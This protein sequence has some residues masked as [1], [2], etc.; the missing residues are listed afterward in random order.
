MEKDMVAAKG[1]THVIVVASYFYPKIGGLE[2]YSYLLAKKL[3]ESGKYR[4]SVI[5][6]NYDGKGYK[7][8][9]IDGMMIH[10]LPV[11]F[12][13][14]NTP[15]NLTW[16][17]QI[18]RIFADDRPDILHLHSPVPFMTDIAA[19]VA[20]KEVPVVLTYH[21]GSMLKNS[22]P[23]DMLLSFYE[24]IFLYKLFKRANKIVTISQ[25]FAKKKFP[26]FIEKMCF[27]PTGVDLTRFK[28]TP[29]PESEII[30]FVGRIE[31]SSSWKGIEQ[32]LQ[33]IKI[34]LIQRPNAKLELVGSGDAV[35]HYRQRAEVLGIGSSVKL[36]GSLIGQDLVDAYERSNMV[37]LPSTSDA[38]AFS[39]VL[40]E[41]MAAG[42]PIIGTNIGGTPQVIHSGE[43]GLLVPAKDPEALSKAI[44]EILDNRVLA[45]SLANTGAERSLNFSWDIQAQK[46]DDLFQKILENKTSR[47]NITFLVS[48]SIRSNFSYRP[49]A[50]AKSLH[51][52]GHHISIIAPKADKYNDFIPETITSID[53]IKILQPFQF[54]TRNPEI[55]LF[56][57]L[58]D[59]TRVLL[60]EKPDLVYI[61]KPTPVSV[62]GLF[63]KLFRKTELVA[64]FDDLGSEVMR[65]E[66]HPWYQRTLVEWSERLAARFADRI[67]VAST[68][69]SNKYEALFP[70]K[71]I[72]IMPNS[73]EPDWLTPVLLAKNL[74]RIIFMGSINRKNIL[75]PLF[76]IFP[77]ILIEE[78]NAELIIMGDGK[79]LSYFKEKANDLDIVKNVTFTGW[80]SLEEAK[81][82][83][84][85]GDI[86]YSYMPDEVTTNA[87]SNMKVSQYMARGV[88]P[89]VS[90]VG[91]LSFTVGF[92][93]AGYIAKADSLDSL[94]STLLGALKDPSRMEKAE[95]ARDI[96]SKKFSW[97]KQAESFITWMKSSKVNIISA[98]S[99]IR[100]PYFLKP[101]S[102]YFLLG[103][104][105]VNVVGL[106][107]FDPLYI[108]SLL[109]FLYIVITPGFLILPL[110][111]KNRF[112]A[113]L[114]I[115]LSAALSILSLMLLGL[116]LNT[117]LP[118]FGINEPLTTIPLLVSFDV[119]IY[120]LLVLN[121]EY[122]ENSAFEFH[123]FN[124]RN[125][126]IAGVAIILPIFA[127]IGA[128]I[129]SNGGYNFTTMFVLVL[130][131]L[132]TL[133]ILFKKE[134]INPSLPPFALYMMA[135]ALLLMNSMRGLYI[136]GHDIMLEYHVFNLTNTAHMWSMALYQDPYMAC[137]SI[138]ILPTILQNLLHI[139][140]L[141]VFKFF[142]ECI[143]ALPVILVYYLSKEYLSEK[144]AFLAAFL[145]ITFPTF[146]VDMAFLNRQGIAFLFFGSML[147]VMFTTE[148]FTGWKRHI[149]LFLF[150]IGM[151]ISHYSTSYVGV[152]LIII[153][154]VLNF[155]MR[156]VVNARKPEWLS[157]ITDKLGNKEAY[158]RP[159]LIPLYFVLGMLCLMLLW[160][161]V[162]T[163][164]AGS[165]YNTLSQISDTVIHPT[166]QGSYS[167]PAKYSLFQTQQETAAQMFTQFASTTVNQARV[168][169]NEP[170]LFPINLTNQYPAF[171]VPPSNEPL[172]PITTIGFTL[173]S[174]LHIDLVNF[175]N[176]FKQWYAK[177]MQVILLVGLIGIAFGFS[178]KKSG[179]L[180]D[181][182]VE[183]IA[184]SLA[185]IIIMVGQTVLPSSDIDYGLLR[186]FQQN[187]IFLTVPIILG[188]LGII[189]V[190]TRNQRTQLWI[191][192]GVL[193]LSFLI[194]SGFIPQ[195]TGGGRPAL[196][197]NNYG[198]YYDA[199]YT[200]AQEVAAIQW[201]ALNNT[202]SPVQSDHYFSSVKVLAY[203]NEGAITGLL[204]QTIQRNSFVYLNYNNVKTGNIIEFLDNNV[205]YYHFSTL[206]LHNEKSLIYDN[207]GSEIYR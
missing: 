171:P 29:L 107:S 114:G 6:S 131:V 19:A 56:P 36:L 39:V 59:A 108:G 66:G 58:F 147:Y 101:L 122:K 112:P 67:V 46:Y 42:R 155:V 173:Q 27:I 45:E 55:N 60:N 12:K 190:V 51:A 94:K 133:L 63:L 24:N 103:L 152:F 82:R 126:I 7:E 104:V 170:L 13:I 149:A 181:V 32:L 192:S 109:S 167:G 145:Y 148:Y 44:L 127:S 33:A 80:L 206:F 161:T 69:L 169:Q 78:P 96:A 159:I 130:I 166:S 198:F 62:I 31:H 129:L 28:K 182:P 175:Y 43:N 113:A 119:F 40:V 151:I 200:H 37:V 196:P 26:Q 70:K 10:R 157:K 83:L 143:G 132:L 98:Q 87:A 8:E 5:T 86:G 191:C 95:M 16:Y 52:L 99:K 81:L 136:T 188:F 11:S 93:S 9:T 123:G 21:A 150:G 15:I 138:T 154:Y 91:D 176:G 183:F 88:V 100:L 201:L 30:T 106:F 162:I 193:I 64:D 72:H 174:L 74:K 84:N 164:S 50:L 34:V 20:S 102:S 14:S 61:Y 75:E 168:P 2:N 68:Y 186:L 85:A 146:M 118:F 18:Q 144:I 111:T 165:F 185:G 57:Y 204:S 197:L 202:G 205:F 89:L 156:Y 199:Y 187:L 49:L 54:T 90:D 180:K 73:V 134:K 17:W 139:N 195:L 97:D 178:F 207:G 172:I 76:D 135:L 35:E 116:G 124:L 23:V 110:L 79:F 47:M 117:L 105:L 77:Q 184:L 1:I 125:S 189:S 120:V 115:V 41:A 53:G 203:G 121:F 158:R 48:G 140:P 194:L 25:E 71:L 160:S 38:E 65:I 137:L 128:I 141:Y 142:M 179:G 177:V 92:G 3:N 22:W 4:V 163:K 153:T